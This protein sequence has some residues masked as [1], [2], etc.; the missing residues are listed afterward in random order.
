LVDTCEMTPSK[1]LARRL[2]DPDDEPF[3]EVAAGGN[4]ILTTGNLRHHPAAA[5][6]DVLVQSPLEVL[7][8]LRKTGG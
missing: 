5:R 7:E 6:A 2:P 1:P 3:L 4:A 8:E